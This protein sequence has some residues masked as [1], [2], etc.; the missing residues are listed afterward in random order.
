MRVIRDV[1]DARHDRREVEHVGAGLDQ[2]PERRAVDGIEAVGRLPRARCGIRSDVGRVGREVVER[3]RAEGAVNAVRDRGH[4]RGHRRLLT[5][6]G[7][8]D[9]TG[10]HAERRVNLLDDFKAGVRAGRVAADDVGAGHAGRVEV[11]GAD[12]ERCQRGDRARGDATDHEVAVGV[13]RQRVVG[14]ERLGHAGYLDHHRRLDHA[15]ER[16]RRAVDFDERVA[17]GVE[18]A[19]FG[20]ELRRVIAVGRVQY[21]DDHDRR[22]AV[23][24]EMR[25]GRLS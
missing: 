15:V 25:V 1:G 8:E 24:A 22:D 12:G 18:R 7:R 19:G 11:V 9:E 4:A 16:S 2:R 5:P 10:H 6:L 3:V 23:H 13:E 17:V 14:A 20:R 21:V